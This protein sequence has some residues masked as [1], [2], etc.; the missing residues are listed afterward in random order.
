MAKRRNTITHGIASRSLFVVLGVAACSEQAR[1]PSV[2][3]IRSAVHRWIAT[4]T[5]HRNYE[6]VGISQVSGGGSTGWRAELVA[7]PATPG[8]HMTLLL[9]ESGRVTSTIGGR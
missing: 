9:D 4:S 2:E 6:I 3:G 1:T 8:G 5:D 7:I